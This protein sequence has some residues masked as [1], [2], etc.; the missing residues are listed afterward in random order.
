MILICHCDAC[1]YTFNASVL[2]PAHD[3]KRCIPYRCPDCGKISV[4]IGSGTVPAV[5][6]ATE[7]EI[8]E[9][10]ENQRIILGEI[11]AGVIDD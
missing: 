6:E 4:H 8:A 10:Y 9:Y 1:N 3:Q 2:P 7:A 11:A 5:R